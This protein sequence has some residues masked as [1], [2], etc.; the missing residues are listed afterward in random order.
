MSDMSGFD[1]YC[2][3]HGIK[4]GEEPAAFAA[5]LNEK[6]GWDG[7]MRQVPDTE[8]GLYSKYEV[9]RIADAEGKHEECR[10]FVLDPQHD[11]IA[12]KALKE[13]AYEAR[14]IGYFALANDLDLWVHQIEEAERGE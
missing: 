1:A 14:Q 6:T 2:E 3:K 4:P 13:Y 11:K 7:Q 9:K 5:Y 8:L 10:Y 12:R